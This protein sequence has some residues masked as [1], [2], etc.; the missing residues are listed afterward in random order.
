M[1]KLTVNIRHQCYYGPHRTSRQDQIVFEAPPV[2]HVLRLP[3]HLFGTH[4]TQVHP[5]TTEAHTWSHMAVAALHRSRPGH[6]T[7]L[8][9]SRS[10]SWSLKTHK[11]SCRLQARHLVLQNRNSKAG[12][13]SVPDCIEVCHRAAIGCVMQHAARF[14]L[15]R[16]M[17]IA[18]I[19]P[20][21][22]FLLMP[23]A[24][25]TSVNFGI[26]CRSMAVWLTTLS[27]TCMLSADVVWVILLGLFS[28]HKSLAAADVKVADL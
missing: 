26:I 6:T 12:G 24:G 5:S 28:Q 20:Q 18:A 22:S 15:A 10:H 11:V 4:A 2:S 16:Q 17:Y 14:G 8:P 27:R 21:H 19:G 3:S 25:M 7:P 9:M 23:S 1:S 13:G